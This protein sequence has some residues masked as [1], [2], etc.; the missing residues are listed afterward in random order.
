MAVSEYWMFA[1]IF[2]AVGAA[3]KLA[4]VMEIIDARWGTAWED[5]RV[6]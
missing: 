2:G 3:E 4:S 5:L 6:L 1:W